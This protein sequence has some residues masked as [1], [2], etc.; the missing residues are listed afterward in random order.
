MSSE[1]LSDMQT[2]FSL[3]ILFVSLQIQQACKRF[4]VEVCF[5]TNTPTELFTVET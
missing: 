1:V 3:Y 2:E 4:I 5:L